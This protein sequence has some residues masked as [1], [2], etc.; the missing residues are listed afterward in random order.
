MVGA[1]KVASKGGG[2]HDDEGKGLAAV[3][4]RLHGDELSIEDAHA[5]VAE[6][7]AVGATDFIERG[8]GPRSLGGE[9]VTNKVG[10]GVGRVGGVP[11]ERSGRSVGVVKEDRGGIGLVA[12]V[13]IQRVEDG[14]HNR[15]N[16]AVGSS[17]GNTRT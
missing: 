1:E 4:H 13:V 12:V 10:I 7:R 14:I 15:V 5:V 6:E 2:G 3:A 9:T 17:E 8:G 16:D 11:I